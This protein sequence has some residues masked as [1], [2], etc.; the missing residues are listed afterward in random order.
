MSAN[1]HPNRNKITLSVG[2]DEIGR[3]VLRSK[4][5]N[6]TTW[7]VYSSASAARR[8]KRNLEKK[9]GEAIRK[10]HFQELLE[11]WE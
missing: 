10:F 1:N 4:G 8:A 2:T 7:Q 3:A 5:P 11:D 6:K 9:G